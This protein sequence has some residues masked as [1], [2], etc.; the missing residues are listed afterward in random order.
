MSKRALNFGAGPATL[1]LPVL[2]QVKEE[3][4][5]FAGTGKSL[6]ETSHRSA[7]YDEVHRRAQ[8]SLKELLGLADEYQ[9]LFFGGGAS[10]QFAMVP[11]NLLEPDERADYLVTGAWAKKA[12]KEA[13]LFGDIHVAADTEDEGSYTRVPSAEDC[14]FSDDAIFVH[15]TTNNTI[16]GTQFHSFPDCKAPLV[17]DMSSDMLWR[18]FDPAPFGLIY[19]GAQK[20][21]G[22]AGVTV[23]VI[24]QDLL[25]RCRGNLPSMMSYPIQAAKDSLYNTPPCFAIYLLDKTLAWIAQLGGLEAMERRNR[26]KAELL[27]G[28]IDANADF[29]RAPVDK[30]SRSMMNV[31]FRLPTPELEQRF[32][33]QAGQQ[34]MIGLKG[35]RSTGGVRVSIYNAAEPQWVEALVAFMTEFVRTVG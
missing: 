26:D 1:P 23:V 16:F 15:L 11:M 12:L 30:A 7:E 29:Y 33:E 10:T 14:A 2:Q 13:R 9:V 20:N 5:D 6:L 3:W 34:G 28:A 32:V 31:V 4:L 22:P 17:A 25:E 24:R 27:Y 35:H 18:A 8:A 21:L 19:A